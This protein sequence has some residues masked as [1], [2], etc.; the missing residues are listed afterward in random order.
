MKLVACD[1]VIEAPVDVVWPM[2]STADGLNHWMSVQATVELRPGGR[3]SWVHDNGWVVA[4]EVRDVVAMRRLVFSYGWERGGFPVPVGSSV[5]TIEVE[6]LGP[7]TR[8]RIRHEGM[9]EPMTDQHTEGWV[10]F[11]DRLAVAA[12]RHRRATGRTPTESSQP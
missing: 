4:G 5:V 7:S 3:I 1:R 11:L 9:S 2:L 8:V 6:A 10:M 12:E